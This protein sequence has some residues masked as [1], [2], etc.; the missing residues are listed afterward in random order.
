M[1]G[2]SPERMRAAI[3]TLSSPSRVSSAFGEP[4]FFDGVPTAETVET[5]YDALDLIRG[6]ECHHW[7]A[8][9]GH[10]GQFPSPG[11]GRMAVALADIVCPV[12]RCPGEE[13]VAWLAVPAPLAR[14]DDDL[15]SC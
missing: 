8:C 13:P 5:I 3:A 1:R 9:P 2:R 14:S 7:L 12:G 15:R 11:A 6:V 4:R 10:V